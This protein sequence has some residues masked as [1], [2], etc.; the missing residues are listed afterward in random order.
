MPAP[1]APVHL[2]PVA[3][4]DLP[5]LYEY[6]ADPE[7]CRMAAV[8]P[9]NREAFFAKWDEIFRDPGVVSRVIVADGK[10]VGSISCFGVDGVDYVGYWIGKEHWGKGFATEGLRLLVREVPRRPLLARVATHNL[11]SLRV[12]ERCGF[13]EIDRRR[14]PGD[15]R[16][17]ACEEAVLRLS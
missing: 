1:D 14:S 17:V 2:R 4:A 6:Q 12:L 8:H 3:P 11:G 13:V 7:G 16:F 9:R 10:L 15:A 5:V